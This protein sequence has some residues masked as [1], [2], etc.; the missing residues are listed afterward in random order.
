MKKLKFLLASSILAA[1]ATTGN[2]IAQDPD[3]LITSY[4]IETN[5]C[6]GGGCDDVNLM[7]RQQLLEFLAQ[8]AKS[9]G[10]SAAGP[11]AASGSASRS[12]VVGA[13]V[14]RRGTQVVYLDFTPGPATET[15]ADA[16]GGT[17]FTFNSHVYT[18]EE[19]DTIQANIEQDYAE[20]NFTFT[21]TEPTDGEFT[22][23]L[24]RCNLFDID[25]DFP[26]PGGRTACLELTA[27]GGLSTLFGQAE[28]ID[29][30]NQNMS[31]NAFVDGNVWEFLIQF[32]PDGSLFTAFSGV[33]LPTEVDEVGNTVVTAEAFE[34]VNQILVN[35]VSNTAA[36][37]LG[38]ILGFRHHDSFGA[39][40][41]GI[42]PSGN[43]A[44]GA[45]IPVFD[46]FDDAA[47]TFNHT[48]ASGASTGITFPL[49]AQGDRFLSERSAIKLSTAER[50]RIVNETDLEEDRKFALRGLRVPNTI[51]V[52]ENANASRI[53]N[54]S[55][56]I[57][58]RIDELDEVDR[59]F[60]NAP[61]GL[62]FMN[63]DLT[64]FGSNRFTDSMIGEMRLFFV[65]GNGNLTEIAFNDQNFEGFN[66]YIFD[67]QLPERGTYMIEVTGTEEVVADFD[68]ATPGLETIFL[69]GVNEPLRTGDYE[70]MVYVAGGALAAPIATA[71]AE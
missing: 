40:G 16:T 41:D 39:L 60:F 22:T 36:H 6:L 12:G 71:S 17:F 70:L 26:I 42:P 32:D 19:R 48:M 59:Y 1:S 69:T 14:A 44:A 4:R 25:A 51:L 64:S 61:R 34:I 55:T 50:G 2:V 9:E 3:D 33:P 67:L 29:F 20:F 63:V 10:T 62:T 13:R 11:V 30:R 37:E 38:H 5:D 54:R 24:M 23:L 7:D 53:A 52:G 45:F 57:A 15:V 35:Q 49:I 66:S 18:Q 8:A 46:G 47:E 28:D 21:Q 56:V 68:P 43:P 65:E 27:A 58:G 31:D